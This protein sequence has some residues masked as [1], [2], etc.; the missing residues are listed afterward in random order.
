MHSDQ[1]RWVRGPRTPL[2]VHVS[3]RRS[4]WKRCWRTGLHRKWSGRWACAR[5]VECRAPDSTA[6]STRY[7]SA[8]PPDPREWRYTRATEKRY[9]TLMTLYKVLFLPA[10]LICTL[11]I[12]IL[13]IISLYI[14]K[15]NNNRW[16]ANRSAKL[17]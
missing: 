7:R 13:I 11:I 8:L 5:P 2:W 9:I 1:R 17:I 15:K 16:S 3:R 14:W 10:P 4:R 12:I 6:P